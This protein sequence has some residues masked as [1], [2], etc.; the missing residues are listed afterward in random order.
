M[1]VRQLTIIIIQI[2]SLAFPQSGSL[3]TVPD[4]NWDLEVLVFVE[5]RKLENPEKLSQSYKLIPH[6]TSSRIQTNFT[7]LGGEHSHRCTTPAPLTACTAQKMFT[8]IAYSGIYCVLVSTIISP[9]KP[10]FF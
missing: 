10:F 2:C 8:L 5:G 4:Q 1:N 6:D 3:S 7:L 9:V